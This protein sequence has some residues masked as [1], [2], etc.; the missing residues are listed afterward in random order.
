MR[1]QV[2]TNFIFNNFIRLQMQEIDI[3]S[4]ASSQYVFVDF[5]LEPLKQTESDLWKL[6]NES[7]IV[8]KELEVN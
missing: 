1:I 5:M 6:N 7:K 3:V 2:N 4:N 8:K